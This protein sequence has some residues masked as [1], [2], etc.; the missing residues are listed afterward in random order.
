MIKLRKSGFTLVEMLMV[1]L[2]IGILAAAILPR[3]SGATDRARDSARKSHVN[4]IISALEVYFNDNWVYPYTWNSSMQW[5]TDYLATIDNFVPKY[6]KTMP[7]DPQSGRKV[8]WTQ[9]NGC[10]PWVYWY[11]PM[12]RYWADFAWAIVVVNL[13]ADE[14]ASN[15]ILDDDWSDWRT[16]KKFGYTDF[17]TPTPISN[18]VDNGTFGSTDEMEKNVCDGVNEGSK[19]DLWNCT[20]K[21][22]DAM[23]YVWIR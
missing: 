6:L 3:L 7:K 23:V 10:N 8:Y 2:I 19:N 15:F 21:D 11:T 4:Q 20:Y 12:K 22:N 1:V 18:D 9:D 5:C 14:K 16:N 13:E 17:A